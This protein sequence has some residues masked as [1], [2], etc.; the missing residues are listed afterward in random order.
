MAGRGARAVYNTRSRSQTDIRSF[1][2][3]EGKNNQEEVVARDLERLNAERE[4]NNE[5]NGMD[6]LNDTIINAVADV[7]QVHQAEAGDKDGEQEGS[8]KSGKKSEK[9]V[10]KENMDVT[11][12]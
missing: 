11:S 7:H 8:A 4:K 6:E 10:R 3:S 12:Q 5:S 1:G 2:M 9:S